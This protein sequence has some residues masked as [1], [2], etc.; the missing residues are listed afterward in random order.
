LQLFNKREEVP[1]QFKTK[2]QLQKLGK[3]PT[4]SP[5]GKLKD[6]NTFHYLFDVKESAP[7]PSRTDVSLPKTMENLAKA[8]FVVNRHAKTSPHPQKLYQLKTT[9]IN[10]LIKEGKAEKVGLQQSPNPGKFHQQTS[11]TL[12]KVGDYG[13]HILSSKEDLVELPHLGD[14][15]ETFRNPTHSFPLRVA[16]RLLE[17]YIEDAPATSNPPSSGGRM[18][19]GTKGTSIASKPL[20]SPKL[21]N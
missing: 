15:S 8:L 3:I 17:E 9:A 10:R 12:V 18:S 6:R 14:W 16:V 1:E 11:N 19:R 4:A 21:F 20:K 2:E 5:V 13:F 7:I